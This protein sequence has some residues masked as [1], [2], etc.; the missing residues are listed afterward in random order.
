MKPLLSFRLAEG[1]CVRLV[2]SVSAFLIIVVAAV[3]FI[4]AKSYGAGRVWPIAAGF[5][6]I[7]AIAAGI[8]LSLAR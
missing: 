4:M 1:V 5:I 2:T 6:F 3:A 7:L 8:G